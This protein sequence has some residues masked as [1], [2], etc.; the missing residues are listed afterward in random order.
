MPQALPGAAPAHAATPDISPRTWIS[1][2]I[3]QPAATPRSANAAYHRAM[4]TAL[5]IAL[6]VLVLLFIGA[7]FGLL[8]GTAPNDLGVR[9]GRLKPPS[10]TP[11]SVSS[12]SRLY[13]EHPQHEAAWIAPFPLRNGNGPASI[14]ALAGVLRS[15]PG[16]TLVE[17]R[18][19]YLRAEARTRWLRF[20][21]DL[22][23]WFD[24]SSGMIE[25]RSAS[26]L[27]QADF[28]V[29]RQRVE[30]IRKAWLALP[31]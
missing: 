30:T 1:A 21:D 22:E 13:P 6:A 15:M 2:E 7:R 18:N 8:G 9:N 5:A 29:N 20:V 3:G 28:G 26:R 4:K 14:A 12:Q 27:G 25:V 16:V 31:Q 11:N 19:D 17:A 23:F 10:L 24:P